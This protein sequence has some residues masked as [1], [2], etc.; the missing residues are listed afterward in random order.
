MSEDKSKHALEVEAMALK[1][2]LMRKRLAETT[3]V[4]ITKPWW[5][6]WTIGLAV[7]T[8]IIAVVSAS[9]QADFT[10]QTGVLAA[11][12]PIMA[13]VRAK[14]STAIGR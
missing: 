4:T 12:G 7:L 10:W 14:T 3:Q 2:D 9:T 5:Q 8:A 1:N 13:F 11:L 6:S